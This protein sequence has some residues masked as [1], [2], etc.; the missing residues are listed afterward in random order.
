M[1]TLIAAALACFVTGTASAECIDR[2]M[3]VDWLKIKNGMGLIAW[4]LDQDGNMVELFQR[5]D[6]MWAVIV[7]TPLRCSTFT[8]TP[9]K[10]WDKLHDPKRNAAGP[11]DR[12]MKAGQAL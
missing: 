10:F 7:T 5:K 9:V 3:A 8:G 11:P 1:K 2:E 4:G 6:G 12:K